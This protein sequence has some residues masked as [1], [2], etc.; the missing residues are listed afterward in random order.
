[1]DASGLALAIPWSVLVALLLVVLPGVAAATRLAPGAVS[2]IERLGREVATGILVASIATLALALAGLLRPTLIAAVLAGLAILPLHGR[3]PARPWWLRSG[4]RRV[5]SLGLAAVGAV[6]VV[7]VA[8]AAGPHGG[9]GLLPADWSGS[10]AAAAVAGSGGLPVVAPAWA[11]ERVLGVPNLP[12][13]TH[14]AA[15]LQLLP[16][17]VAT[18]IAIDRV[19]LSAALVVVAAMLLRRWLPTWAA[20]LGGAVFVGVGS[21]ATPLLDDPTGARA[22]VLALFA[23]W[24]AD[25]ALV[26]RSRRLVIAT[27]LLA[28]A[29]L[30]ARVDLFAAVAAGVA[31][32]GLARWLVARG[33]GPENAGGLG[34]RYGRRIGLRLDLAR[35]AVTPLAV[36]VVAVVIGAGVGGAADRA[37]ATIAPGGGVLGIVSPDDAAGPGEEPFIG[38]GEVPAGWRESGDDTWDLERA[39]SDVNAAPG[40]APR[41]ADD[42]RFVETALGSLLGAPLAGATAG[43]LVAAS[44]VPLVVG[45]VLFLPVLGWPLLD[46]RRQRLVAAMVAFAVVLA[47]VAV[48]LLSR[49]GSFAERWLTALRVLPLHWLVAAAAVGFGARLAARVGARAATAA[50]AAGSRRLGERAGGATVERVVSRAPAAGAAVA[51][52]LV[53]AAAAALA[54]AARASGDRPGSISERGLTVYDWIARETS[55]DARILANGATSGGIAT[56]TGRTGIIDGPDVDPADRSLVSRAT[57]LVLGARVVFEDPDGDRAATFLTREDVSHL[58]VTGPSATATD[59][60]A[61]ALV[62]ADL[63]AIEASSRFVLV[64]SFGDLIFLYAVVDAP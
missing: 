53:I 52:V 9:S 35:P 16:G 39:V 31:A 26:E 32:L 6:A 4:R 61:R 2:P 1:M 50:A 18:R 30:V 64:R 20:V 5:W 10:V 8:L 56:L 40:D 41:R 57:A 13:V 23:L 3:G 22:V 51:M 48:A 38:V 28:A 43:G 27:G 14:M 49:D 45:G 33:G 11:T 42:P 36:A 17:D 12:G 62:P 19:V 47:G 44:A 7:V 46:A 55:P 15:A 34:H 21:A 24:L 60:G 59:L 29:V 63:A 37:L 25:R 58:L 54:G